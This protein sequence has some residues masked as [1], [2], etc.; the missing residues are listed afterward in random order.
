MIDMAGLN[1]TSGED[2]AMTDEPAPKMTISREKVLEEVK[3]VLE[4]QET[5]QK[6]INLVVIG[7][8]GLALQCSVNSKFQKDM[9]TPASPP[10]WADFSMTLGEWTRKPALLMNG[11]ATKWGRAASRGLGDSMEPRRSENGRQSRPNEN[12]AP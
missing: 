5:G 10:S 12:L 1:L 8:V 3:K 2:A 11:E 7:R 4:A 6:A 9:L